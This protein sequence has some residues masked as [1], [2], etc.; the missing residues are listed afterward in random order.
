VIPIDPELSFARALG[1]ASYVLREGRGLC[2]FPEG[3][4]SADGSVQR[5]KKGVGMLAVETDAALIPVLIRG[6]FE[7][8]PRGKRFINPARVTVTFGS[9]LRVSQLGP[10]LPG[11]GADLYQSVADL[12]RDRVI[13]LA[14][15]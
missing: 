15:K 3:G 14:G 12:L 10:E 8:L 4:R 5:F 11:S 13:S 2:I 9:P 1:L 7:A 6:T